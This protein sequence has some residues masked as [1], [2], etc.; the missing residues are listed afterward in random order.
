M[1]PP[2]DAAAPRSELWAVLD[3]YAAR[4]ESPDGEAVAVY[5]SIYPGV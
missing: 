2:D 1:E 3:R 5:L 4:P